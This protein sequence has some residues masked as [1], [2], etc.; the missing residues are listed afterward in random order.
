MKE[1]IQIFETLELPE[2]VDYYQEHYQKFITQK[3]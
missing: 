3:I 1:A 2:Q